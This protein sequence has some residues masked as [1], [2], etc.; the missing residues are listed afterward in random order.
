METLFWH[1]Q[2]F[3]QD[4]S[5]TDLKMGIGCW[6]Q[7]P[8]WM[9]HGCVQ[10][11]QKTCI[12][13]GQAVQ[14]IDRCI[15]SL[16]PPQW[17]A[18]LFGERGHLYYRK[19]IFWVVKSKPCKMWIITLALQYRV[20]VTILSVPFYLLSIRLFFWRRRVILRDSYNI[21]APSEH[22]PFLQ[23]LVILA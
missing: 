10:P 3:Y 23:I 12:F 6:K 17:P 8:L 2:Y 15:A 1:S 4:F 21:S 5:L 7:K 22:L 14:T 9:Q 18:V 19:A 13:L 16:D 11:L 20:M